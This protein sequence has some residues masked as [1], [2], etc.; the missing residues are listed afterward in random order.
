IWS[1]AV[2]NRPN[3]GG[4]AD[5]WAP[6]G[7]SGDDTAIGF[8]D[9]A[10]GITNTVFDG[11]V[12]TCFRVSG[13]VIGTG[14]DAAL[15]RCRVYA[16]NTGKNSGNSALD[17]GGAI[18]LEDSELIGNWRA[19]NLSGAAL[20]VSNL[21]RSCL[22][23]ENS[24]NS[25]G[26]G[27][28]VNSTTPILV[29]QCRFYRNAGLSE[30]WRCSA[31]ITFN[32]AG[33]GWVG[34]CRFEENRVR[35]NCHG[36][37]VTE[38]NG[39][40]AFARCAFL[41]N[42]LVSNSDRAYHSA[43][44][45]ALGG[46]TLVRDSLF[47]ANSCSVDQSSTEARAWGSAYCG[48]GGNTTFL[49]TTFRNNSAA[50]TGTGN[51]FC[52][53]FASIGTGPN[54]AMVHCTVDGSLLNEKSREFINSGA[55]SGTTFAIVDSVVRS[56]A[57]AYAPFSVSAAVTLCLAE[58]SITG[59]DTNTLPTGSNGYLYNVTA[60][61]A[62]LAAHLTPV[63]DGVSALGLSGGSPF[64]RA[65]RPVWLAADDYLYLYDPVGKPTTP[66]RRIVN[67]GNNYATLASVTLSSPLVPDAL[68]APRLA[69]RLAYGPLNAPPA[70]TLILLH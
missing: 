54:Y 61:D 2:F 1:G 33:R 12:L 24:A 38:G 16:C 27:I 26:A 6:G 17:C 56:A 19:I 65:G 49:N 50:A 30:A 23:E 9:P 63:A 67:K 11:V 4:R 14:S 60:A 37:V 39:T 53:T 70:G 20:T 22:F 18:L 51:A 41:R 55:N 35:G 32:G 46:N 29:E 68:G 3:P 47:E 64:T 15:T 25:Y 34:D 40:F 66:W 52:G 7:N 44:V 48:S 42:T 62:R 10:G 8:S 21:L 13:L 45:M 28:R 57:P 58:S 59:I 31:T 43:A 5:Y 36:N 69:G